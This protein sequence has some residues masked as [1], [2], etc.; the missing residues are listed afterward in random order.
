MRRSASSIL[1]L[2]FASS[3]SIRRLH[4]SI[5][6]L[7]RISIWF[8]RS[9]MPWRIDQIASMRASGVI[10]NTL[11]RAGFFPDFNIQSLDLLIQ[12][13]KRDA[14][15]FRRGGLAPVGFLELVDD[16][17]AFEIGHDF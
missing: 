13:R 4:R 17:A 12:C 15:R 1:C 7:N 14:K 8:S 3:C 9:A 5:S 11:S 2:R 6:W 10:D 16:F